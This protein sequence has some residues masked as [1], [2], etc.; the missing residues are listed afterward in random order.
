MRNAVFTA[1]YDRET[2]CLSVLR[3][4][5]DPHGMNWCA[6]DGCWGKI[7]MTDTEIV[8]VS[9]TESSMVTSKNS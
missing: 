3:L 4:N 9:E 6:E 7:H 5:A 8:S 2:G 1:E